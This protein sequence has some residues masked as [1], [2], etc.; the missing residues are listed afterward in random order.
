VIWGRGQR[1]YFCERDLT[2]RQ[3]TSVFQN[4]GEQFCEQ[5]LFDLARK[6]RRRLEQDCGGKPVNPAAHTKTT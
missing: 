1:K 6:A 3:I 5:P 4:I 2:D